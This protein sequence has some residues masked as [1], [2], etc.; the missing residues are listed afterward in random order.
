MSQAQSQYPGESRESFMA[1]VHEALGRTRTEKPSE[2]PPQA[3]Q[4][5]VRLARPGD[6]LVAMF[7]ERAKITGMKVIPIA[8][9]DMTKRIVSLL[10]ELGARKLV[11]G[12]GSLPQALGLKDSLRRKNYEV[13]DWA[14]SPGLEVQFEADAGITDVHAALAETGTLICNS[15]AGHSRGLSLVPSVHLAIVRRSDI[16]P[17]MFDYWAR[18]KGIP[19]SQLPSSMAFITGPSKTADIE[20]ELIKG[21]HGPKDVHIFLVQDA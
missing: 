1:R 4:D 14:S 3:D 5:I 13:I 8:A 20:G 10:E 6:D 16:L 12:V 7:E 19:G 11:V 21:V 9:A 15:D 17:D 2:P 18:L